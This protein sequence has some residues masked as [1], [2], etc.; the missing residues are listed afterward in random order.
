MMQRLQQVERLA[1]SGRMGRLLHHPPRYI[2]AMGFLKYQYPRTHK[3]K[4]KQAKTFFGLDMQVI[5]PAATDIYLTGGKTHDSEIR[6]AKYLVTSIKPGQ[7]F[8]DI[9]AHFGY[10]TLLA[11]Q[12][13]GH[14]GKVYAIEAAKNTFDILKQNAEG[15]SNISAMHMAVSDQ[16]EKV[17][18]Y[19]FPVLY[20]EYNSM[21]IKQFEGEAW[22]AL[23]KPVR[24]EVDAISL[25]KLMGEMVEKPAFIKIDVEGIEDRVIKGGAD[26][27]QKY[28]PVVVMEFLAAERV[29]D[30]HHRA[31]KLLQEYGYRP[32]YLDAHGAAQYVN[33][34]GKYF[35]ENGIE[36]D[37][38]VFIKD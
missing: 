20:S 29:N 38:I 24:T 6:L 1:R 27:L 4:F 26:V 31:G 15:K 35:T 14:A 12:L 13:V 21:D 34:I 2:Q 9:G 3:G 30:A 5:L 32:H 22:I 23:Y 28:D 16:A 37:N 8:L 7:V 19:E 36:S 25:D 18:F 10:Y 11:S 33:D 17:S